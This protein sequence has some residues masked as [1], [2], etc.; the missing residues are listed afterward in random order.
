MPGSASKIVCGGGGWV[1]YEFSD[2][3]CFSFSLALA[4]S[5]KYKK[6]P[7][8]NVALIIYLTGQTEQK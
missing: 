1:E 7:V 5:N 6:L 3:P 8:K 2:G 4:K